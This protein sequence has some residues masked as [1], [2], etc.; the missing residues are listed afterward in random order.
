VRLSYA[1]W[2]A[3]LERHH[4]L[5]AVASLVITLA[6][7]LS[8]TRLRL[9]IDVLN[10]LPQGTPAFDDFKAFVADF[11]ELNELVILVDGAEPLQLQR[12]ADEFA[13]RLA[14]LD[15]VAEVQARLDLEPILE[16]MLGRYV[17]NYLRETDYDVLEQRLT[18]GGLDAQA[19]ADRA[20]LSAPFD[21]SA[22]R[23]VLQDPL[24][25]RR[26]AAAG[27][28]DAYAGLGSSLS[29]GY[30]AS[31]DRGALLLLAR[32]RRSPFDIAFSEGLLRDVRAVEADAR[33]AAGADVRVS[34]TGS[35]MFALEDAATLKWDVGRYTTLALFGILAVFYAGYRSLRILPF[36][37]YPLIATTLMTFALSL[38]VFAEL[39]AISLSFA[40][41]LYG[42]SIDSGIY[43][44]TR[45]LQERERAESLREAVTA[46]LKGL[47]RANV[48][49]SATTAGAFAVIGFSVL[50][51]VRQLGIL[52]AL[53]MVLTTLQF[54]TVFPALSFLL[55]RASRMRVGETD[56][57]A[58]VAQYVSRHARVAAVVAAVSGLVLVTVAVR[59]PL[60]A[61]LTHLRPSGSAA[62]RVQDEVALRFGQQLAGG[63]VLVQRPDL[64]AALVDA[65]AVAE[66]LRAYRAE[67]VL[68]SVQSVDAVLP[69]AQVQQR[70]L[71]RFN[72]L[73][74]EAAS[75]ALRD[76]LQ[77]HG[78]SADKFHDFFAAFQQPRDAIVRLDDP[79]LA[80]L[81]F[82]VGHHVRAHGGES[83]VATYLQ[84]AP[85]VSVSAIT[86]RLH[87]DLPTVSFAVA[88]RSALEEELGTVMRHELSMFFG[89]GIAGNLALLLCTFGSLGVALAILAPVLLVI[90]ALFAGMWLTGTALDPVN[91]IVTPLI[92]GIGV[93][94]GVYIVAR[95]RE[96]ASVA[97]AIRSAGR[98][99]VV[100]AFTTIAGFGFL[101]LSRYPPLASMGMLA[102]VGLF[103]SLALSIVLLPALLRVVAPPVAGKG[104]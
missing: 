72:R 12:F 102:G 76:A 6:S 58:R 84:P 35:Y 95:A 39:N 101:G 1:A 85:G 90:A 98:A 68:Q 20:I 83:I 82:L 2:V 52:T 38:V 87:Q 59:V 61:A 104:F 47:G 14:R 43:F 33:S 80:P 96:Q 56:R 25:V 51:A 62:A 41:I 46:T 21:L 28:A 11:G 64:E 36:V 26:F 13:P 4:R 65:E 53:G 42:L 70:R 49:A 23:L 30:F 29:G 99:V 55:P 63:A 89:F 73:P 67:G 94:Y 75:V 50:G 88:A 5:I 78:F 37:T 7:A 18:P 54:F 15:A 32:P 57:L 17:Y 97:A 100:T 44:Y 66:R 74:R 19:A 81:R 45:L 24:G 86:A 103:L 16:G 60:D 71:D 92:F 3:G 31:S 91:L 93:D 77:R 79:V 48:A 69:S 10:M 22:A 34:Y 27:F 9:D 40:A 8:L